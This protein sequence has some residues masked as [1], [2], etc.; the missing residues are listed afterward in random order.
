MAINNTPMIS[1]SSSKECGLDYLWNYENI[2]LV[3]EATKK[4]RHAQ[5]IPHKLTKTLHTT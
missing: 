3:L 2:K 5:N 1:Y 4:Q